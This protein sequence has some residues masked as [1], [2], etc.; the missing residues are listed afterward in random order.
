MP[1]TVQTDLPGPRRAS[2]RRIRPHPMSSTTPSGRV[3]D[4]AGN[5]ESLASKPSTGELELG[6]DTTAPISSLSGPMNYWQRTT[7]F[8]LTGAA[9][10]TLSGV[11]SLELFYSYSVDGTD[12]SAWVPMATDTVAPY[13]FAFASTRGDGR[14]RFWSI[15]AD[16]A[17][18]KEPASAQ[19]AAGAIQLRLHTH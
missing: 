1:G 18:D 2:S 15:A 3:T 5:A 17:G 13:T 4:G 6:Y 8:T 9:S 10:D 7:Q 19:P 11:G 14:Y 16:V 12:W